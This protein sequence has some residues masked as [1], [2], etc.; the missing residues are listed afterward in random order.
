MESRQS[1]F[2]ARPEAGLGRAGRAVHGVRHHPPWPLVPGCSLGPSR[3]LETSDSTA[4]RVPAVWV[5]GRGKATLWCR[6]AGD[7]E[8]GEAT[9]RL[10]ALQWSQASAD[11]RAARCS[12]TR[13]DPEGA[14]GGLSLS[15]LVARG[16]ALGVTLISQH[17]QHFYGLEFPLFL[18]LGFSLLLELCSKGRARF[19][20]G[21]GTGSS[22]KGGVS[23]LRH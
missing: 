1:S 3:H 18:A 20:G 6:A 5:Q 14:P 10:P 4:G 19:T 23:D 2:P 17:L 12:L 7:P 21:Q 13:E 16:L 9:Q 22:R 15:A 8:M 11:R